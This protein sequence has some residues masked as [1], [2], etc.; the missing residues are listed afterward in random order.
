MKKTT[1]PNADAD[2]RGMQENY[3][4]LLKARQSETAEETQLQCKEEKEFQ[5]I[6]I[7]QAGGQ[8]GKKYRNHNKESN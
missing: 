3:K 7:R 1:E 5:Q 2:F 8:K 6:T 4:N